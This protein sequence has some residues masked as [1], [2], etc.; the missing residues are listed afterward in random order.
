MQDIDIQ[1]ASSTGDALSE[2]ASQQH[3]PPASPPTA[4]AN[5]QRRPPG[6]GK[7]LRQYYAEQLMLPEWLN[8][9]PPD[10]GVEW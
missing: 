2:A 7:A 8:E 10:L 9:V 5:G 1:D 4:A 6:A 3:A